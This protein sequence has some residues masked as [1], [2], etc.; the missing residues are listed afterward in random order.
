MGKSKILGSGGSGAVKN[1]IVEQFL[2]ESETIDANTFVEFVN[3]TTVEKSDLTVS[4]SLTNNPVAIKIDDTRVVSA[5]CGS[6]YLYVQVIKFS[7]NTLTVG[8]RINPMYSGASS[9]MLERLS[10]NKVF[11][12]VSISSGNGR[13][14]VLTI[15]DLTITAGSLVDLG[16][17]NDTLSCMCAL[18]ENT[19]LIGNGDNT[20]NIWT[21][22]GTVPTK[23][24][25]AT[26][27]GFSQYLFIVNSVK[28]LYAL[29]ET[30]ALVI[31]LVREATT[32]DN[33]YSS[34]F[35]YCAIVSRSGNSIS[36]GTS[37]KA[38]FEVIGLQAIHRV[39]ANSVIAFEQ[40]SMSGGY[41]YGGFVI[42][43]DDET[44]RF[45]PYTKI[46][47]GSTYSINNNCTSDNNGNLLIPSYETTPYV[48]ITP[49]RIK[50][51]SIIVGEKIQSKQYCS[52]LYI[53]E[54]FLLGFSYVC[55]VYNY[56][57]KLLVKKS[58]SLI[59]GLSK[60]KITTAQSGKVQLLK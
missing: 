30:K 34:K 56:T 57:Q 1:S 5:V 50:G 24:S 12:A 33:S 48:Y 19:V 20:I 44:I 35:V 16:S 43:A 39:K 11:L 47:E 27:S 8:T 18:D 36:V 3:K 7:D 14:G 25:S 13:L 31:F 28:G 51:L 55:D 6:G 29:S 21:I 9:V 38:P 53:G 60:S 54:K 58:E 10:N 32:S 46:S 49:I 26:I 52:S 2:A 41:F 37:T 15:N 59:Q 22:D 42:E 4:T 23:Q 45:G 17:Y 40:V